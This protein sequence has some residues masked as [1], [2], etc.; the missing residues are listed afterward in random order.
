MS[1][2]SRIIT[3]T[4]ASCV[5]HYGI[6]Q[7]TRQGNATG[8]LV[9]ESTAQQ[10]LA[11]SSFFDAAINSISALNSMVKKE[12][13]RNKISSF[14]NPTSS[15]LGFNLESQIQVALKPL[16]A[17]A[18]SANQGKFQQVIHSLVNNQTTTSLAGF[19]GG[20]PLFNSIAGIVG[21]FTITEKR[22][23]KTDFDN[24]MAEAGKYFIQFEKLQRANTSFHQDIR[25]LDLRL[26]ELQMDI[27]ENMIDLVLILDPKQQRQALKGKQLEELLLQHLDHSIVAKQLQERAKH[28]PPVYY[29]ADGIKAAKDISATIQ[30]I[31]LEYQAV[32]AENYNEVRGILESSKTLGKDINLEQVDSSIR[33]VEQLYKESRNAD[34]MNLRVNTLLE[35]LRIL[36][37]T[38]AKKKA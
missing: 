17:K 23:T 3:C 1:Y 21:T 18:K 22:L 35:R 10:M 8:S 32:Y 19:T 9:I 7:Q 4:L 5:L 13:Y 33:E 30:K 16:L 15:D 36:V 24:F 34:V 29:P 6:A 2:G 31:F 25:K 20:T 37:A 11:A 14:N 28:A 26:L 12:S 38:E 27:R